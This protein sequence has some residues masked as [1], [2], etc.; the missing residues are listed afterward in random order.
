MCRDEHV[1]LIDVYLDDMN[2]CVH[3][4]ASCV[5]V[6]EC[7]VNGERESRCAAVC[8]YFSSWSAAHYCPAHTFPTNWP[9]LWTT[10]WVFVVQ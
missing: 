8:L 10:Y 2:V 4:C 7:F 6:S 1:I 5:R 9:N 3:E